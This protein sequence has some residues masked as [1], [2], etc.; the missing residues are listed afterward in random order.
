MF[1]FKKHNICPLCNKESKKVSSLTIK[2]MIKNEYKK[3]M[4]NFEGF[5][6]CSNANCNVIYFQEEKIIKQCELIKKVGLKEWTNPKTICYCFNLTKEKI[7]ESL[8]LHGKN[9][10][11]NNIKKKMNKSA[12]DCKRNNPSGQCCLKDI[13]KTINELR[14]VL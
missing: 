10:V 3:N 13:N 9:Y 14:M 5:H 6:F 7:I 11:L 8:L 2:S 4:T 1:K 12:C